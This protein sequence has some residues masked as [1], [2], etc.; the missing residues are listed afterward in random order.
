MKKQL[1][2]AAIVL[3]LGSATSAVSGEVQTAPN[4]EIA[5]KVVKKFKGSEGAQ[6]FGQAIGAAAGAALGSVL[7]P[8]GSAFGAGLGAF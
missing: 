7:G 8:V 3:G 6:A 4:A 1:L 5:Y 2:A